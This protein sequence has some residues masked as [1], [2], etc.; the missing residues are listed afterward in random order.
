MAE[1][2]QFRLG[3]TGRNMKLP[4]KQLLRIYNKIQN[5]AKAE[6]ATSASV[7]SIE[8]AQPIRG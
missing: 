6:G 5:E 1:V 3:G 8:T 4:E 2:V 7:P